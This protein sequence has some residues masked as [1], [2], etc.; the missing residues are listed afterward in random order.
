VGVAGKLPSATPP[1]TVEAEEP[2]ADVDREFFPVSSSFA[3]LDRDFV[4]RIEHAARTG[5]LLPDVNANIRNI[6]NKR[7]VAEMKKAGIPVPV[8][9][10]GNGH[11]GQEEA[12]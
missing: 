8:L 2:D 6:I 3:V 10:S 1:P 12:F 4:Q 9:G 7:I 11:Q 5:G